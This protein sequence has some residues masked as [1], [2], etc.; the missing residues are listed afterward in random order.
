[1]RQ[2]CPCYSPLPACDAAPYLAHVAA[3][4]EAARVRDGVPLARLARWLGIARSSVSNQHHA[5]K[6][7]PMPCL[8]HEAALLN[9]PPSSLLPDDPTSPLSHLLREAAGLS[10]EMLDSVLAFVRQLRHLTRPP[11]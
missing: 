6:W 9:L 5:H 1:M 10:P 4:L 8:L 7:L 2:S 3:L 11:G